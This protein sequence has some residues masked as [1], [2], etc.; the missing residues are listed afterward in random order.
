MIVTQ[1]QSARHA[2]RDGSEAPVYPLA[3]RLQRLEAIGRTRGMNANDFG[4]G[5]FHGDK[6]IGSTF[7][8]GDGLRHIRAPHFIDL[9]SDDWSIVQSCTVAWVRPPQRGATKPFSRITRRTRRGL[10]R[11][12][13]KRN[14]A[15]NLR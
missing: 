1:L 3:Y 8:D 10:A 9:V 7:P 12:P 14:R 2:G 11:T 15:H 13:E 4:I 5:V 6:D